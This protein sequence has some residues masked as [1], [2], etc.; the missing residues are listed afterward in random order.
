[1]SVS[2]KPISTRR[3]G[4]TLTEL[5]I[6]ITLIV[7]I[8][9]IAIPTLSTL[10]GSRSTESAKNQIAA[11]LGRTRNLALSQ[12]QEMGMLVFADPQTNQTTLAIVQAGAAD[13]SGPQAYQAWTYTPTA[14]TTKYPAYDSGGNLITTANNPGVQYLVGDTVFRLS[15]KWDTASIGKQNEAL[16]PPWAG[17]NKKTVKTFICSQDNIAGPGNE[18][19]TTGGDAYWGALTPNSVNLVQNSFEALPKGIGVELLNDTESITGQLYADKY[20][21]TGM[22]VFD[23]TGKVTATQITINAAS[24]LGQRLRL[25]SNQPAAGI[26]I[27]S[28]MAVAVYDSATLADQPFYSINHNDYLM[29]LVQNLQPSVANKTLEDNWVSTNAQIYFVNRYTGA[30][31]KAE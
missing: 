15:E 1:M 30:L 2:P 19:G 17:T 29:P 27:Y 18:P 12:Q 26:A 14:G 10:T 4:F 9:G 5:L 23:A 7:I 3:N 13:L 28:Q 16:L 24:P 8:L 11:M 25:T 22:V 20:L 6:V 31:E 21:H